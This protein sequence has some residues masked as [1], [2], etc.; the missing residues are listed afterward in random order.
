MI[1]ERMTSE[2]PSQ[3]SSSSRRTSLSG[4]RTRREKVRI[5]RT[6]EGRK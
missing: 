3:S 4:R 6:Y 1:L 5:L 2:T